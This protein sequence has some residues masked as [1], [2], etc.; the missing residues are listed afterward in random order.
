MTLESASLQFASPADGDPRLRGRIGGFVI[1]GIMLRLLRLGLDHPLWR[2]EAYL[3]A[4]ILERDYAGLARP[5]DYQ[6]VCP[7]LFLWIEKAITVLFGFGTTPLRLIPTAASIG[8]LLL[9]RHVAGRL[10]GG[11]AALYAVAILAVSYTPIRHGG[12]IKPY[13]TDLLLALG[14]I[15]LTIGWLGD[16]ERSGRLWALAILAPVAIAAS[17]PAIFV[18]AAAWMTLVGPVLGQRSARTA[19][20]LAAAG[21]AIGA[22]FLALQVAVNVP[23]GE[24]VMGWMKVY[25]AGSFPPHRAWPLLIWLARVHTGYGFGYPAGGDFGASTLTTALVLVGVAAM[26]RRGSRAVLTLL[27]LPFALGLAAATA[28]RYPYG[29]SARIMQYLA[30]SIILLEGLGLAVLLARACRPRRR[31]RASAL[32]LGGLA[33]IGVGQAGWDLAMPFKAR[34]DQE[35]RDFA[36]RFWASESRG[37][38]LLCARTALKLPL[39]PLTWR[40]D[41][42]AIYLCHQAIFRPHAARAAPNVGGDRRPLRVVVF[43]E[44]STDA[45]VVRRWI[46]GQADHLRLRSRV[47][48]CLNCGK[49][50]GKASLEERYVVYELASIIPSG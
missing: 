11:R 7:V 39:D 9:L 28:G 46:D 16:R 26:A 23:Q 19:L 2:D 38:R 12:E 31:E 8:S 25:W 30:P 33:V 22:T 14:L 42:A 32:I 47:E 44:T 18:A 13:A 35:S 6:Q 17:N 48:R 24:S 40:G 27:L 50:R 34:S 36:R 10:F 37:C 1:L 20:P 21:V 29:G 15:A 43:N 45:A 5:L 49:W 4:N 3:A 41:R